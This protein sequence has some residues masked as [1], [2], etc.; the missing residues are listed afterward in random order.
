MNLFNWFGALFGGAD[1]IAKTFVGSKQERDQQ[2][3]DEFQTVQSSY[4]AEY[5]NTGGI[6]NS[7][8]D[9]I[10]RLVRPF[11]TFGTIA[12]FIWAV[13]DA[14]A[15][16]DAMGALKTVP[17]ELWTIEGTIIAFWFGSKSIF[18]DKHKYAYQHKTPKVVTV[19]SHEVVTEDDTPH[20]QKQSAVQ[21]LVDLS[22]VDNTVIEKW[23]R[24]KQR[25]D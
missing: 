9:G 15:F 22:K 17:I 12:L 25:P 13:I 11:F 16:I 7:L 20:E 10:N 5:S 6:F 24:D 14:T 4:Q 18:G 19:R 1:K 23:L 3:H 8:V 2:N 21:T